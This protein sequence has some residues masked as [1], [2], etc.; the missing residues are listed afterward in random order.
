MT[1]FVPKEIYEV[2]GDNSIWFI[3]KEIVSAAQFLR[4]FFGVPL[5]INNWFEQGDFNYSG[6]RPPDCLI[7]AKYSQHKLKSAIDCRSDKITPA[8]MREAIL[9]NEKKF[10]EAGVTCFES[11]T[12]TWLHIDNRWNQT[13]SILQVPYKRK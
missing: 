3:N 5:V 1:E 4:D 13:G 7:G 10:M 12:P 8:E 2:Y 9:K 11:D 6:Y